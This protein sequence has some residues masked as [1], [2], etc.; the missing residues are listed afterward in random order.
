[1]LAQKRFCL[2]LIAVIYHWPIIAADDKERIVKNL[3][4]FKGFHYLA[5]C[6][7]K[8]QNHI[9]SIAHTTFASK[10]P[11]RVARHVHIV[12]TYVQKERLVLVFVYVLHCFSYDSIGYKLIS[13]EGFTASFHIAYARNTIYNSLIVSVIGRWFQFSE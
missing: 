10:T 7:I 6:P 5:Y 3:I 9:A 4:I 12:S 13:P 1:M 11:I 8:L 2:V